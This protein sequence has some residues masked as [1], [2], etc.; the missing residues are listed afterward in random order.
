ML[1][2]IGAVLGGVLGSRTAK[3]KVKLPTRQAILVSNAG[4]WGN[5]T[6]KNGWYIYRSDVGSIWRTFVDSNHP[7][8]EGESKGENVLGGHKDRMPRWKAS[9][10]A[11]CEISGKVGCNFSG[12]RGKVLAD[13]EIGNRD[14]LHYR[15]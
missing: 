6:K 13:V 2:I 15:R 9:P 11:E 10:L 8:M 4:S 12:W 1:I 3:K 7:E 5:G 14:V